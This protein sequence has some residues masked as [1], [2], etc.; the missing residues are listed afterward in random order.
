V[1]STPDDPATH[2]QLTCFNS[3]EYDAVLKRLSY[4]TKENFEQNGFAQLG[5]V[6]CSL[7]HHIKPDHLAGLMAFVNDVMGEEERQAFFDV[8]VKMAEFAPKLK[9]LFPKKLPMLVESA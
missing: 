8:V 1:L 5:S 6:I 9:E 4:I 2:V 3:D 7:N